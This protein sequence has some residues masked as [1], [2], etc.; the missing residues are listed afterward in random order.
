MNKTTNK[1]KKKKRMKRWIKLSLISF[2]CIALVTT[3]IY[4]Y[5]IVNSFLNLTAN[6][7]DKNGLAPTKV[8]DVQAAP[9]S[10]LI[11]GEGTNGYDN[12]KQMADSINLVV[13]NPVKNYAEVFS[14]PRD[15]YLP[16]GGSCPTNVGSFDKITH[17]N[18]ISCLESSLEPLFDLDINYYIT[19]NFQGFVGIVDALGGVEMDVP[20]LREGFNIFPGAPDAYL[21]PSLKNGKQWC[22]HNLNRDPYAICF[23]EFGPQKVNGEEA[24][25]LVRS[26][27]YD[28]DFARA[29]RQSE[30]IKA[31]IKKA[32]SPSA[33]L[34]IN[35]LLDT[36]KD[37]VKTNISAD[38]FLDFANLGK[39]LFGSA[40]QNKPRTFEIRTT[41][42]A[43]LSETFVGDLASASYN[44]VYA[45]SVEDIRRKIAFS[46]DD[47]PIIP[48]LYANFDYDIDGSQYD[49]SGFNGTDLVKD[50]WDIT[51]PYYLKKFRKTES[52]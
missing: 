12:E 9:F 34:S 30:L 51:D 39:T 7:S 50:T 21:P 33:L 2:I 22:E 8:T 17:A 42:L 36:I 11:M 19:L 52:T 18:E 43:G 28:S 3:G 24:L 1:H 31:I 15:S 20:D 49:S 47:F 41:Q 37:N 44:R 29:N 5:N 27:H 10:I 13:L 45:L 4:A 32:A 48:T 25:A 35:T 40:N 14:V 23:T 46:L 26:R 6:L 16:R 38:Q